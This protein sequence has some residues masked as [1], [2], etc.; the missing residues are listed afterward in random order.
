MPILPAEIELQRQLNRM[1]EDEETFYLE[2]EA[3]LI[4]DSFNFEWALKSDKGRLRVIPYAKVEET[5]IEE[6]KKV[7][8]ELIHDM[9]KYPERQWIKSGGFCVIRTENGKLI[10][11][12]GPTS[13]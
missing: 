4:L 6:M 3:D 5:S 11:T 2:A 13:I 10:L 12:F 8:R 7:A 9:Q 1:V